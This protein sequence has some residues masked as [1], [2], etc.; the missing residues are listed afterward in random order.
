MFYWIFFSNLICAERSKTIGASKQVFHQTLNA[1]NSILTKEI[2]DQGKIIYLTTIV[3]KCL[4]D[5]S[6]YCW[7]FSISSMLRHSLKTFLRH[8]KKKCLRD[9]EKIIQAEEYLKG[10]KFHKQLRIG[11]CI[12]S[13]FFKKSIAMIVCRQIKLKSLLSHKKTFKETS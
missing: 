4:L 5:D 3:L 7:A 12:V 13:E 1:Q 10:T 11:F 2:H 8:R 9:E 6:S